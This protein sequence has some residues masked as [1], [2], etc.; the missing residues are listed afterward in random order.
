MVT[1]HLVHLQD[2]CQC[3]IAKCGVPSCLSETLTLTGIPRIVP[4]VTPSGLAATRTGSATMKLVV[5][6]WR[7]YFAARVT[8]FKNGA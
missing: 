6:L 5:S 1:S 2:Q 8:H 4:H 7:K 3:Q